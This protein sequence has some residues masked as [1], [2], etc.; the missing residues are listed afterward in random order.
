MKQIR[1]AWLNGDVLVF[2]C[3]SASYGHGSR[4]II[5]SNAKETDWQDQV[6]YVT[7]PLHN[8]LMVTEKED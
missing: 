2:T 3:T 7:I 4:N 5:L 1:V 6:S 8:V